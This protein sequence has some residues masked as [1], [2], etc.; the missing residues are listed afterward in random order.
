MHRD[1]AALCL[2]GALLSSVASAQPARPLVGVAFGGGSARGIAHVGVI[3]WFEEHHIPIDTAAGTS[4]GGL[5][6]GAFATGMDAAELR[7]LLNGV[8][9]DVM[10]GSSTFPFKNL[11]RK[12]DAR[13][14]PSRL[15]FGL[16]RGIVPPTSLN[17]GQQVDLFLARIAG[18]YYALQRFDDLPTPF[19]VVA[20]DLGTGE[21]VVIESGQLASALRATMSLP[22]VFPPVRRDGRIL[23]D[24]GALDNIPADV[25]KSAGANVVIAVDV[26]A[27]PTTSVDYSLFGLLGQTVDTMMRANTRAALA[28]ADMTIAVDVTGFGSL[29]WR[30][31]D[32]LITRGYEAAE[33]HRDELLKY[34][35]SDAEWSAWLAGRQSRRKTGFPQPAF[36][37]TSGIAPADE[38]LVRHMLTP[39]LNVPLDVPTLERQVRELTGLDRYLSVTWQIIEEEG[40]TGLLV[41]AEE[42][43]FAPPFLMLGLNVENTTSEDFRVRLTARYLAFDKVGSG[44]ELRIDGAVGADPSLGAALYKP[45]GGPWFVHG[46]AGA[47]MKTFTAIRDGVAIGQYRER[48]LAADGNL[49]VNLS[50]ESVLSGGL[51]V[52]HR[53]DDVRAGDPGLPQLSGAEVT[54]HGQWVLDEQD[55]PV[56]PSRGT[57]AVALLSRTLTSPRIPDYSR[58]NDGLTQAEVSVSSFHSLSARN[59]VFAVLSGGTSFG[60]HPLPTEQFTLGYPYVLDAFDVGEHRGDHYAVLTL[61]GARQMGRLPDFL[62]GPVFGSIWLQNGAAFNSH[63]NADLNTHLAAGIVLDTLVGPVLV[64]ASAGLDGGWRMLFGI[65]RIFR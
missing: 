56:I 43:L 58:T 40:R 27:A 25:V 26:G 35:L 22:A 59:R 38:A 57:R 44:S 55:S 37:K 36:L 53:D 9:W 54:A 64:G 1:A 52:S 12:E 61:G 4:M 17:D 39:H 31:S 20:V 24:G 23:V 48:R 13:S 51:R 33:R 41:R 5:I 7:T 49:G 62:G 63:E 29:D 30:R 47:N 16:K 6:G 8:D 21:K 42:K 46:L 45:V 10:F 28:H 34:R 11:R 15:E 19:R 32:E 60:D 50:R 65:G 14:Y 18:P 3:Q 2:A